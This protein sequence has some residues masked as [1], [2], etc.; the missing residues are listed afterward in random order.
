M[1][2]DEMTGYAQAAFCE[3]ASAPMTMIDTAQE[4]VG[5]TDT[6]LGQIGI[7]ENSLGISGP[8]IGKAPCS[9]T[10]GECLGKTRA[11]VGEA[12][13]RLAR[14]IDAIGRVDV[15]INA[16]LPRY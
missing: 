3:K 2:R 13:E 8:E 10:M 9:S 6:L 12:Q 16:T 7:I 5:S 15:P 4:L 1:M 14:L 11:N